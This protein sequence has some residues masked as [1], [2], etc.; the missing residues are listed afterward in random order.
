M[1]FDLSPAHHPRDPHRCSRNHVNVR[2]WA[3]WRERG[4]LLFALYSVGV[5]L[6]VRFLIDLGWW[7]AMHHWSQLQPRA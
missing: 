5:F 7:I 4:F 6:A 3:K 1:S 2:R